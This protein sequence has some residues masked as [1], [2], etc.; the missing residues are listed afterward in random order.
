MRLVFIGP[1]GSGK[2]TQCKRLLAYLGVPHLSTGE[3]L[4]DAKSRGESVGTLAEQYMTRGQLVPDPIVMKLV[5][6]RLLQPDCAQGYLFDGFPRTLNQARSLDQFLAE[7]QAP[8]NLV[9]E[10]QADDS[11]LMRRMLYR[12]TFEKRAD[13]TPETIARRI[14]VYKQQTAP[15]IDYYRDR[16]LLISVNSMQETDVVATEIKRAVDSVRSSWSS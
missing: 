9:L 8:L 3:M 16:N 14:E 5:G 15:L 11:E 12:A 7:L 4:R 10:L 1:P 2:G 13:D 6:M